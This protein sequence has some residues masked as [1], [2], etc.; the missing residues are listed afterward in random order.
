MEKKNKYLNVLFFTL[1]KVLLTNPYAFFGKIALLLGLFL[2]II[3]AVLFAFFGSEEGATRALFFN[4]AMWL[5]IGLV[6]AL[7][8]RIES[9]KTKLLKNNG[10]S[11]N[12]EIL[13]V[14]PSASIRIGSMPIISIEGIYV[15][16][17]GHRCKVRSRLFFWRSYSGEGLKAKIYVDKQNARRYT[18]EISEIIKTDY[19]VDIDY[20]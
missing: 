18:L 17:Q 20:T 1:D 3:S 2:A 13:N 19:E 5:S 4:G 15:N 6:C 9:S 16:S 10:V 7:Y 14:S 8:I 11:Y 12:V